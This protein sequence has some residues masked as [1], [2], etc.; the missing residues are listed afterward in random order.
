MN[1]QQIK[2]SKFL[3]LVLRHNPG[4]IGITLDP[5]GWI[6]IDTLLTAAQR[7][8]V[9]INTATLQHIVAENSKQRFAISPDGRR[10]RANQ[11]HSITV[12]LALDPE[13]PPAQLYHGT[14][15]RFLESIRHIGL[16]KRARHHVHLSSDYATAVNVGQRHGKPIVLVIQSG[17]MAIAGFSFFHTANGVW[18]T[19]HVPVAYID[20]PSAESQQ[21]PPA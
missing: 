6:E 15:I 2:Q 16:E 18:L 13:V 21:T 9:A 19:D 3:S 1:N 5:H 7:H 12:D 8:G 4:K 10:I 17:N 11:G 20:F 14:A